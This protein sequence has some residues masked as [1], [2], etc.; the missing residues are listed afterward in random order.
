MQ[1]TQDHDWVTLVDPAHEGAGKQIV[2]VCLARGERLFNASG[3]RFLD[4]LNVSEALNLEK[5]LRHVLRRL[6]NAGDLHESDPRGLQGRL[7]G[8]AGSS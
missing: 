7:L 3:S 4:V 2:D 5:L 8:Q 6:A 1:A